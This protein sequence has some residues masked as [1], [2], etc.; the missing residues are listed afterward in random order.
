[1]GGVVYQMGDRLPESL[2][3]FAELHTW[4]SRLMRANE[5]NPDP[6][7]GLVVASAAMLGLAA[8]QRTGAGQ[9]VLVDMFGANAYANADDFLNY[10]GKPSR[11]MPDEL[12]HGFSALYRLYECL[13]E[14]WVFLAIP[15]KKERTEFITALRESGVEPPSV[16]ILNGN[17]ETATA[18]LAE[19]LAQRTADAWQDMLT[20]RGIACVRADGQIPA[21]FWPQDD[22]AR[23]M[24]FVAKAVHPRLGPYTRHGP[25]VQFDGS[26][27]RLAGPP[28]AG[29]HNEELLA[30]AGFSADEFS[31]MKAAGG[32]WAE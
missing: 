28:L 31:D 11:T 13:D 9:R 1:M 10:P 14:Q 30:E 15:S 16:E 22:Q 4:T 8:R 27:Q 5:L 23:E 32:I 18:A 26:T 2:Q 19:L 7:T 25:V 3:D 12:M 17:D 6:N 29:Q 20:A 21:L 24:G